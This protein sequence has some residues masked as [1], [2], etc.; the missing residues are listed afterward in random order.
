LIEELRIPLHE[1]KVLAGYC[2]LEP[3]DTGFCDFEAGISTFTEGSEVT[4]LM[5]NMATVPPPSYIEPFLGSR[6]LPDFARYAGTEPGRG[7]P[8]QVALG[9]EY[10]GYR[11]IDSDGV[12]GEAEREFL[13]RHQGEIWRA[14]VGDYG[15]FGVGWLSPGYGLSIT[16]ERPYHRYIAA[17]DYGGGYDPELGL[18]NL[19]DSPGSNRDVWVEYHYDAPAEPGE[20]NIKVYLHV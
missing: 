6:F 1:P 14:N 11:D 5:N 10:A 19:L 15:Y 4:S 18:I 9:V 16:P 12:I 13:K 17:Y 8:D 2:N 7:S 3:A 20:N